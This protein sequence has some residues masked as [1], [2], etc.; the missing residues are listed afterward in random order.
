M[1]SRFFYVDLVVS[2]RGDRDQ[3]EDEGDQEKDALG[4]SED[5]SEGIVATFTCSVI[6]T[7]RT[8]H[9]D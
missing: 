4:R 3:A 7:K 6:H 2:I 9:L 1:L 5:E 8:K